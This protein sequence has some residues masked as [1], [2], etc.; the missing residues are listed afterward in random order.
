[1]T[2]AELQA[3][4]PDALLETVRGEYD[5]SDLLAVIRKGGRRTSPERAEQRVW[6]CA[7]CENLGTVRPLP[8]REW[9]G[10]VLCG[11]PLATKAYL[12]NLLFTK[13]D[14]PHPQGSRWKNI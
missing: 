5:E 9:T 8:L 7:G 2:D 13:S 14:C 10:C 3:L 6:A 12:E 4:A 1:M 11:C